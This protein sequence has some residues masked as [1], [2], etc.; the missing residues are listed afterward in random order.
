MTEPAHLSQESTNYLLQNVTCYV[1]P[2]SCVNILIATCKQLVWSTRIGRNCLSESMLQ[3]HRYL[4]VPD[5]RCTETFS[6]QE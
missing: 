1:I 4:G 6:C 3:G 2:E 5:P